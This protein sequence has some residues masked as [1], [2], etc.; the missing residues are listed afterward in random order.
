MLSKVLSADPLESSPALEANDVVRRTQRFGFANVGL[1]A[2][3]SSGVTRNT[4]GSGIARDCTL[5]VDMWQ[6]V[7]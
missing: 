2:P 1:A 5:T 3:E 7:R 4:F 6:E